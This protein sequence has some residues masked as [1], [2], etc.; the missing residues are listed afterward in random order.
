MGERRPRVEGLVTNEWRGRS[1]LVTGASGLLG[2]WVVRE[3][4]E[5]GARVVT[6]VRDSVPDSY[7]ALERLGPRTVEVRGDLVDLPLLERV[8]LEYEI[9]A[10]FHLAA[11]T[12]VGVAYRGPFAT[13]E[14]NVRGTYTLL[15]V[16]RRVGG[17]RAILIA[18]SDKAYGE[19]ATLPYTE[20]MPLLGANPYDASKAAADLIGR[21]YARTFGMPVV[22]TRCANL[23]GAG[24]TNWARLV[25][26]TIRALLRAERP[27][28]RS[29]GTPVR[30]Y[31]YV[32]DAVRA[33]LAAAERAQTLPGEAFN[34]SM[35]RPLT[36]LEMY[37]LVSAAFGVRAEPELRNETKA[38]IA[39]QFLSAGKARGVLG[40]SPAVSLEDG[41]RETVAWYRRHRALW[42]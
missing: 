13:F 11:Q 34:L 36:V 23:F 26:G 10:I 33:C 25:P 9:D 39:R 15:D 35:E 5:R 8:L 27:V 3:L 38:E 24:D 29:D 6:L 31:L 16:A 22:V 32:E 41:L 40:W 4:L 37:D 12:Q 7:L 2:G 30:D 1:V 19:Q 28:I 14:A 20:D 42:Q 17:C 21:S 18:S